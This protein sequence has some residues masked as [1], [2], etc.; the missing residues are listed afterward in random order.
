MKENPAHPK[1]VLWRDVFIP[2]GYSHASLSKRLGIPITDLAPIL[3]GLAPVD[4]AFASE[5]ER[6]GFGAARLWLA[7]QTNYDLW[8]ERRKRGAGSN[9]YQTSAKKKL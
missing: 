2:L 6:S 1:E 8:T 5:L 4:A 9:L 7:L 3:S